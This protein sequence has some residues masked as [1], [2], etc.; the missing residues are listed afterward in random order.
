MFPR[1]HGAYGQ[2]LF[3]LA[4]A[5]A[6]G[7]PGRGA[8]LLSAAAICA[9][10]AHEP[11]L[12]L[13]GHRGV[14][15]AREHRAQATRWFAVSAAAATLCGAGALVAMPPV[16]R[17]ALIVPAA[18]ALVLGALILSRHEHS[19]FGEVLT[20]V[21]LSS[22]AAPVALGSGASTT[23]AV[24]CAVVFASA[25][26]AGTLSVRAV[27][28]RTRQPPA[29]GARAVSAIVSLGFI[30]ALAVLSQN[31]LVT[32]AAPLAALPMCGLAAA[33]VAFPPSARHLRVVGWTLVSGT[34]AT[35][36]VLVALL[37]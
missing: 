31:G 3:P 4:T 35:A 28:M 33:L 37:G 1:E 16:A 2:L 25:L 5:L 36:L 21:A 11:L 8:V 20:A 27:I 18:L 10:L 12:V 14:R 34:T 32:W 15:A 23:T 30:A 19:T 26:V 7:R 6:L 17:L 13:L 24:T 29:V 22:L 9:F